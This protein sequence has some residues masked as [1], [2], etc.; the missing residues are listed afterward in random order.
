MSASTPRVV[1]V[2]EH[3]WAKALLSETGPKA[4][5]FWVLV[6]LYV[7]WSW[8]EAG[9]HKVLGQDWGPTTLRAYWERAVVVPANGRAPIAYGWYRDFL[10]F[11]MDSNAESWMAG[12]IAVGEVLIGVALIVGILVGISAF[13]GAFMNMNF[14]LA[15]SA[16]TNPV[17][18]VLA[19][20]LMLGWK[21]A[22]WWGIDRWLLPSLGTP[23][24]PVSVVGKKNES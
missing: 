22:G 8:I 19:V 6:R 18:F 2:K 13:F 1:V 4:T 12:A 21:T 11:L 23:W 14:M 15:G 7:G 20:L 3:P 24:S 5:I 17:L 10:Q 9:W 16:S